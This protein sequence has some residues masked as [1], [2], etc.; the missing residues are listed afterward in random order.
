MAGFRSAITK[1]VNQLRQT[2]GA[3][4]WQRNYHEHIIRDE[5]SLNNVRRYIRANPL[6]WTYDVENPN[7][8]TRIPKQVGFTLVRHYGFTDEELDFIINYDIKRCINRDDL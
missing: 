8:I 5:K 6:M 4:F 2:P 1:R 7:R 3:P